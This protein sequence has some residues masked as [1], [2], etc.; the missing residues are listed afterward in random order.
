VKVAGPPRRTALKARVDCSHAAGHLTG[1]TDR[2][3]RYAMPCV[4]GGCSARDARRRGCRGGDRVTL[5]MGIDQHRAQISAE[6]IDTVT[7][8]IST[9]RIAPADRVANPPVFDPV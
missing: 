5:V 6:W 9:T 4:P 7:G 2:G 8:E 3:S 1:G